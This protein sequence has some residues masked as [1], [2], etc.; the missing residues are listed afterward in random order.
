MKRV[1]PKTTRLELAALIT[2]ALNKDGLTA[3][4]VG[5]AVV[6][7]YTDNKYESYDLDFI[8]P[9][10]HSKIATTMKA[11]GFRQV[12]K[13]FEH[14]DTDLFVE[15]PAGPIAIGKEVPVKLPADETYYIQLSRL[16]FD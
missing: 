5:G 6:S 3:V 1:S 8:S 13:N 11:L 15:F 12:G 14:P 7:I 9:D 4:L 16:D 10:D 2:R